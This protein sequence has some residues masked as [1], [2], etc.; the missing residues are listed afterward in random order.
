[1]DMQF[2]KDGSLYM[3]E[4]GPN[5]FA[6]NDEATLSRITYNAGNRP[7]VVAATASKK[8]G[9]APLTVAF[10]SKGTLDY[11]GDALKYEWTFAPGAKS[12]QPN[13][14][15]TFAKPGIYKPVLKVTDA[16]GN[17]ATSRLEVKVGNEVPNVDVLVKGNRSF[18]WDNQ[19][20]NYEVKVTDKEDGDLTKGTIQ[21]EDVALSINYLE[22]YDKTVIAQGHQMNTSF[23][24]G[25]RL[26]ELSDCKACH[27]V[28]KK[29]IGPTYLDVAKKYKGKWMIEAKL[30]DKII[31][32]G[33]GVWGDQPMS[34]HP[35][36]SKEEATEMVKYILSLADEKKKEPLKGTYTT[37]DNGKNGTYIFTA[38]Y[39]DRGKGD[40][41]PLTAD[42]TVVLRNAKTKAVTYDGFKDIFKFKMPGTESE[43]AVGL[44]HNAYMMFRNIDLTGLD[45]ASFMVFSDPSRTKGGTLE[46]RLGSPDGKLVGQI[47]VKSPAMGEVK[48]AFTSATG[49][50][51]VY[52]VF[53]NENA[54]GAP[55]FAVDTI[56][57]LRKADF[58]SLK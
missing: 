1:M 42:K 12:T 2:D 48:T 52:F 30:A 35:Q 13:P 19:P 25:K 14:S 22:G 17:V 55:L 36:V 5:W 40:I 53:K 28:D 49:T 46:V 41:G 15:F 4:Y 11:D 9:A 50:H 45:G 58:Q 33:G 44:A 32:G 20:V 26:V 8:A 47:E 7:P 39:T 54:G 31:K 38:S 6:Q 3:L 27:A 57:F 43:L 10:S 56:T 34:A 51:D 18:F 24:A 23:V 37:K 16:K 21:P 29:S